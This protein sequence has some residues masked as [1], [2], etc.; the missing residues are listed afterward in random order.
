MLS[1][2]WNKQEWIMDDATKQAIIA[3]KSCKLVGRRCNILEVI[4]FIM[5]CVKV[6]GIHNAHDIAQELKQDMINVSSLYWQ[7]VLCK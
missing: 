1:S 5:S 2:Q 6:A 4:K 3:F 7:E